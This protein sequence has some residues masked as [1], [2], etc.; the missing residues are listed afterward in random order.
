MNN[1]LKHKNN[2][3]LILLMC[4]TAFIY[5]KGDIGDPSDFSPPAQTFSTSLRRFLQVR[6][7]PSS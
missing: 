7:P 4:L 5:L 2:V 6:P 1:V 3:L